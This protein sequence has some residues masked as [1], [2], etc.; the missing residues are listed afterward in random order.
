MSGSPTAGGRTLHEGA[1]AGAAAEAPDL[2][3]LAPSIDWVEAADNYI[4][5]HVGGRAVMKRMTDLFST[6]DAVLD[7][8]NFLID[9]LSS[10]LN[11][12]E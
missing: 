7:N 12:H 4:E 6:E 1:A 11:K 3:T 8:V 9:E 5:L 10:G 2:L